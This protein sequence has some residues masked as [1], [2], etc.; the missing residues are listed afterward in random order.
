M[1]V[2]AARQVGDHCFIDNLS[3][4]VTELGGGQSSL[5]I[6]RSDKIVQRQKGNSKQEE[7]ASWNLHKLAELFQIAKN[8]LTSFLNIYII[9]NKDSK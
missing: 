6:R 3:E 9:G 2:Q 4:W 1:C 8:W 7:L 5:M